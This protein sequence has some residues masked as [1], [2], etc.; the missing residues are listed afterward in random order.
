MYKIISTMKTRIMLLSMALFACSCHAGPKT[1][2]EHLARLKQTVPP[3]ALESENKWLVKY[4]DFSG[5]GKEEM[6]AFVYEVTGRDEEMEW[7]RY[8]LCYSTQDEI[9]VCDT[10]DGSFYKSPEMLQIGSSPAIIFFTVGYGGPTGESFCWKCTDNGLE[11]LSMPG[12]LQRIDENYFKCTKSGFDSFRADG[13]TETYSPGRCFYNYYYFFD[14]NQFREYGGKTISE[15]QFSDTFG[16]A[17]ILRQLKS[18]G[19]TIANIYHRA[20]GIININCSYR[21]EKTLWPDVPPK[22]G[23]GFVYVELKF[24]D[25]GLKTDEGL[26]PG[27]IKASL[28]PDCAIYP[29]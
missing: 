4:G 23:T 1:Y 29:D 24:A 13:E 12:E 9:T 21:T 27:R 8:Y 7:G 10:L 22:S 28:T 20:N 15:Q 14:G 2:D 11:P 3:K 26:Q 5:D 6:L 18:E 25:S 16:G 17:D 19:L